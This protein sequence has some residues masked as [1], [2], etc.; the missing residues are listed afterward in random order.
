LAVERIPWEDLPAGTRRAVEQHTGAV[1]SAETVSEGLNSAVAAILTTEAG[2]VFL[3][4]LHRDY[5]RRWT[6]DRESAINPYVSRVSP[7]LLWRVQD[8][9]DL[10]GFEFVAGEHADYRPGSPDLAR[11]AATIS[12]LGELKCP[13]V[14]VKRAEDRW[15]PYVDDPGELAWLEGDRLLHTDYNPFNVLMSDGRAL[16]IDWA[17]PTK[18]AGWIDPACLVLRLLANGHSAESAQAVVQDVAAWRAAPVDGIAVGDAGEDGVSLA[19]E[20]DQRAFFDLLAAGVVDPD[21]GGLAAGG[22]E[23]EVASVDA[24]LVGRRRHFGR[25]CGGFYGREPLGLA[26]IVLLPHCA[27]VG[28]GIRTVSRNRRTRDVLAALP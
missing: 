1:W 3:K 7:R 14:P 2:A 9:W 15:R 10:L 21:F 22:D 19:A 4:G 12:T 11:V 20:P 24:H 17:W 23:V 25:R 8:E 28:H 27:D 26:P 5:P 13:D 16:L 6:H 18:G